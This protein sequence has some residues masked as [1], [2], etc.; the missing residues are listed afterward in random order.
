MKLPT[1]IKGLGLL[2]HAELVREL[3]QECVRLAVIDGIRQ[4]F[5][6]CKVKSGVVLIGYSAELLQM[7]SNVTVSEGTVLAFGDDQNG[8]GKLNIAN[9]TWLGQ[10]NNIRMGG[11]DIAI[12]AGCLISQ[13]CTLVASGHGTDRNLP[14]QNQAP[15]QDRRGIRLGDD[16]WLGAGVTITP[17]VEIETG[18]IIGAGSVVTKNV[19]EYEIWGGV[20]AKK[21]ADRR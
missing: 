21:I 2:R 11:G 5:P 13:F 7:G 15:P 14:I 10:Y 19:P 20:P 1:W 3:S 9:N 4:A 8:Y 18:A 16:V 12:G 17:G 6:T